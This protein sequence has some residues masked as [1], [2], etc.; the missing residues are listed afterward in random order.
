MSPLPRVVLITGLTLLLAV[1]GPHA[2]VSAN[3]TRIIQLQHRD[4]EDV[5]PALRPLLE[6]GG[7]ISG[8]QYR[9]FLRTSDKNFAEIQRVLREIDT[10]LRNLRITV[11]AAGERETTGSHQGVSA[12][13]RIGS[14]TRIVIS[15]P[16]PAQ[17]EPAVRRARAQGNV[18]YRTQRHTT[19]RTHNASQFV[20]VLDGQRAYL[21]VGVALPQVQSFLV[22]AQGRLTLAA[23]VSYRTVATGF[24]VL[25]RLH[26]NEVD[27]EITPRLAFLGDQGSQQ[28]SFN[29]LS[30]R[31]NVRLGEWV[32]LGG[33]LSN[34][35]HVGRMIL[36]AHTSESQEQSSFQVRVDQ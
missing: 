32:D 2:P 17:G 36:S 26:G 4:A 30:T 29:E 5:L 19:L 35:S 33:I 15:P 27:L 18:E 16:H 3:E 7:G 23:G 11:R 28:V 22:L 25:P 1:S 6:S 34:A 10:P 8:R 20:Q 24:E 12:D 21:A 14:N 13:R 31:V 9:L